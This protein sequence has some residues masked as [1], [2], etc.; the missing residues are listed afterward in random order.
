MEKMK[1]SELLTVQIA[2]LQ[3]KL[4]LQ[5]AQDIGMYSAAQSEL[6]AMAKRDFTASGVI[7]QI[8]SLSG[9][10]LLSP[11]M[12]ANGLGGSTIEQLSRDIYESHAARM[13]INSVKPV[14]QWK[15][16]AK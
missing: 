10:N 14:W 3:R 7:V 12:I 13:A 5:N 6:H 2:E 15:G 16:E 11:V 4:W 9:K 1:K 8:Q